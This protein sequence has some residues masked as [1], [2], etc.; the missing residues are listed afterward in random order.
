MAQEHA[1]CPRRRLTPE[2]RARIPDDDDD[3]PDELP[4]M[5]STMRLPTM[6]TT[7]LTLTTPIPSPLMLLD[8]RISGWRAPARAADL[9]RDWWGLSYDGVERLERALR[10]LPRLGTAPARG[11]PAA[12]PVPQLRRAPR[13]IP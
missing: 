6:M 10:Q 3:A 1:P 4:T 11:P 2:A 9:R 5:L 13:D 8:K 7:L 12:E